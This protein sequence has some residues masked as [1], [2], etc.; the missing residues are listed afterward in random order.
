VEQV[1]CPDGYLLDPNS[2]LADAHHALNNYLVRHEEAGW[3]T[4]TKELNALRDKKLKLRIW[5]ALFERLE[6]LRENNPDSQ[7]FGPLRDIAYAIEKWK[8]DL[9]LADL[10]QI[11]EGT[12]RLAG[13]A[14]TY[15][16]MPHLMAYVA[17]HG[18]TRELSV[19]IHEYR[20]RH[21]EAKVYVN[22]V[23]LQLFNSRMDMLAW[24]DEWDDIDSKKCWSQRIRADFRN[25]AGA[26]REHW[27][28]FLYSIE[29]DEGVR[30]APKWL[31]ETKTRI[32]AIGADA[33]RARVR[34]WLDP[35]RRGSTHLLSREGS[36]ILRSLIWLGQ[37]LNDPECMARIA[38]IPDVQFK[39]KKNAEKILRA[40]AEALGSAL[41]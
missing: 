8:L 10:L 41:P 3:K 23:S 20:R 21:D 36:Y 6:W 28:R 14:N 32:Q 1:P 13:H 16:P 31:E 4:A 33:F 5:K 37:S 12:G 22:Q 30:P 39:P 9:S 38:E 26:E 17:E 27:R 18:L 15:A 29:G 7:C 19:A 24:R 40:A 34:Y 35:L 25:L 11:L 2:P